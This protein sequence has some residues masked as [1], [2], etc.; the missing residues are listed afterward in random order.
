MPYF[1]YFVRQLGSVI[2]RSC[3][4]MNYVFSTWIKHRYAGHLKEQIDVFYGDGVQISM[5]DE[6]RNVSS[7]FRS[8]NSSRSPFASSCLHDTLTELFVDVVFVD[9]TEYRNAW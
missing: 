2:I 6:K 8:E 7:F 5:F 9:L 3:S 1:W 4:P